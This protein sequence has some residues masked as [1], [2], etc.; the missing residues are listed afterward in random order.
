[1]ANTKNTE[2]VKPASIR[3]DK[4]DDELRAEIQ[5]LCSLIESGLPRSVLIDVAMQLDADKCGRPH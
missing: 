2:D 1:M 3:R 4:T 5:I